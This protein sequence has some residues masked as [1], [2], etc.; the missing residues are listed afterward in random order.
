ME[1]IAS[2]LMGANNNKQLRRRDL[3]EN[4]MPSQASK[5]LMT[6]TFTRTSEEE[7][8]SRYQPKRIQSE[9]RSRA[10]SERE[11]KGLITNKQK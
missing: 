2:I 5:Q 4:M 7:E 3:R 10:S 8:M 1:S 9:T 11:H 6:T